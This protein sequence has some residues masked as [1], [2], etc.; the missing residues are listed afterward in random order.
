MD[1]EP[2]HR[3]GIAKRKCHPSPLIPVANLLPVSTTPVPEFIDPVFTKTSP[4]RSFSLNRKRAFWLVFAKTGSIISG[5][6][7]TGAKFAAGI[8]DIGGAPC[9]PNI[10]ENF[11]RNSKWPNY[12]IQG[13]GVRWLMKKTWSNKSR[14]TVPLKGF[15]CFAGCGPHSLMTTYNMSLLLPD[16]SRWTVPVSLIKPGGE[17][18]NISPL[19]SEH[20]L[21]LSVQLEIQPFYCV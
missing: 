14:D 10:S 21:N 8:V 9:L 13:L 4:K 15:R 2:E 19:D 16:L 1:P 5:T 18:K 20:V 6:A 17:D 11:R 12:Y 7:V 3:L